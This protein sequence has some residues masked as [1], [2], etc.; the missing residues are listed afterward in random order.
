MP[1]VGSSHNHRVNILI[2]QYSAEIAIQFRLLS[3]IA[4]ND[5]CLFFQ[6]VFVDVAQANAV[7]SGHIQVMLQNAKAHV[8]AANQRYVHLIGRSD[9][10]VQIVRKSGNGSCSK[11]GCTGLFNEVSSAVIHA[12]GS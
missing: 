3:V 5:A 8:A 11:G 1:V 12:D 2:L 9:G 10:S 7:H 4:R 6:Y